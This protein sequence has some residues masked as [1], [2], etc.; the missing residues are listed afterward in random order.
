MLFL[1]AF[2]R[3]FICFYHATLKCF[4]SYFHASVI[5]TTLDF[6]NRKKGISTQTFT[7]Q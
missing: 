2:T 1:D 7:A 3:T 6:V 4:Y 5:T